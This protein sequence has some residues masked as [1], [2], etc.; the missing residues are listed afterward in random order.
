MLRKK[1]LFFIAIA[2]CIVSCNKEIDSYGDGNIT[3]VT[4]D[5]YF[6][7]DET[8]DSIGFIEHY[9]LLIQELSSSN[10]DSDRELLPFVQEQLD[11]ANDYVDSICNVEGVNSGSHKNRILG[12][13]YN[14]IT[15]K[16]VD[17]NNKP[18][19]LSAL[20]VWPYNNVLKDP[21]ADGVVM[22][23][24]ITITSDSERPSNYAKNKITTD[25]GML[26][27]AA[28]SH[29]I[30]MGDGSAFG[31]VVVI[32]DYQGYGVSKD[33]VHPYLYQELTARQVVDGVIAGM[34]YYKTRKHKNGTNYKFKKDWNS[35]SMGYS[36]GGSV[37][38][39]V[40]RYI[41]END[42]VE[43]FNFVGSLCGSG[44]YDP[45]ATLKRY[46]NDDKVYMP[47]AV[48]LIVKGL[49]DANPHIKG[50]YGVEDFFTKKFMDTGIV[51]MISEKKMTTEEIQD[52]L[53]KYSAEYALSDNK[54]YMY[55]MVSDKFMP[56]TRDNEHINGWSKKEASAYVKTSDIL[57]PEVINWIK[58][59]KDSKFE[60]KMVSFE[61]AM[62][63]NALV[64]R[65]DRW[66]PEKQLVL[67]HG[68][69]DEVVTIDNYYSVL[70]EFSG[71]PVFKS[72]RYTGS[73][74][75]THVDFGEVFYIRY[76]DKA[77]R[78]IFDE[79][80]GSD[81][82]ESVLTSFDFIVGL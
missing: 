62:T 46:I 1:I 29:G 45:M 52:K 54:F 40:H 4:E 18:I 67:I 23:C 63:M 59:D 56:Y 73:I 31:N 82:G 10:D 14:T 60:D 37:A 72:F 13:Q 43:R 50:K 32:P 78:K 24:H 28:K 75:N 66:N 25:V 35:I 3:G 71:S 2:F 48:A 12:Y 39:A 58:G 80:W 49:V 19:L 61:K 6:E 68:E 70:N 69:K 53:L 20:V 34:E 41:E 26:A 27:C 77:S 22:G 8:I 7:A 5:V 79:S 15:Y 42:L 21:D 38:M 47:V 64:G 57:C 36:Q 11:F 30:F 81:S 16:S 44:P 17:E 65:S 76:S 9:E 33:R 55:R 51:D 74:M